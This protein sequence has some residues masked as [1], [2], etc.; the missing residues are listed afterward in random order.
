MNKAKVIEKLNEAIAW[1]LAGCL[2]YNQYGQVL[3]GEQRRV[4]MELFVEQS[5]ESLAHA[6]KFA[7]RV[8]FLG[9]TPVVEPEAVK[10]TENLT[11]MLRNSLQLEQLLVKIYN[12][13]LDLCQDNAA[14]RNLLEDHIQAENDDCEMLTLYLGEVEKVAASS[15]GSNMAAGS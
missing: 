1:E 6:R 15:G 5:D 9:G 13:A 3:L 14:Y 7:E 8:V 11:E 4:W 2:Q 12:E 10:Q